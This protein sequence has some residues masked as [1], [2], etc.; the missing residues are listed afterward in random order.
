MLY[1]TLP[2]ESLWYEFRV[3]IA[4]LRHLIC[5]S[6]LRSPE[7]QR[8]WRE[9]MGLV[10]I[11]VFLMAGVGF[12]TFGFTEAVCGEPP[13]RFH[14]GAIGPSNIDVGFV[15]I[16]GFNYNLTNWNHPRAGNTFD[17]TKSVLDMRL[18]GLQVGGNDASFLFQ[19]VNKNCYGHITRASDSNIGGSGNFLD[20]YVPCNIFSTAVGGNDGGNM[21][22]YENNFSCHTSG[23]AKSQLESWTPAGQVYYTWEDIRQGGR[24]L[25]VYES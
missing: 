21:T 22:G 15:V 17:G 3:F 1:T 20:W 24:N 12:L 5:H 11:I 18:F 4:H 14:G 9:K 7:Q 25:A 23:N 2:Y 8:A 13:K 16:H 19:N 10:S 6:G